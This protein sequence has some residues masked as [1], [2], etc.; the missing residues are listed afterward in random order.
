TVIAGKENPWNVIAGI[1]VVRKPPAIRCPPPPQIAKSHAP[2]CS[3]LA[4]SDSLMLTC[5]FAIWATATAEHTNSSSGASFIWRFLLGKVN[6]KSNRREEFWK[7]A[8]RADEG[9]RATNN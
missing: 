3:L 6:R 8:K 9:V 1:C 5:F 4:G 7:P 2:L